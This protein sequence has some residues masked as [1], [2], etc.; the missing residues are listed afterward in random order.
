M[1]ALGTVGCAA[2]VGAVLAVQRCKACQEQPP[3]FEHDRHLCYWPKRSDALLIKAAPEL[4]AACE[5]CVGL[6]RYLDTHD[7]LSDWTGEKPLR[8]AIAKARGEVT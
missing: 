2:M 8:A 7:I 1:M 3:D 4:L 5:E 6:L